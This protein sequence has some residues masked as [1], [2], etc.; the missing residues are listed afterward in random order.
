MV[1][2]EAA[3]PPFYIYSTGTMRRQSALLRNKRGHWEGKRSPAIICYLKDREFVVHR[4]NF[5]GQ[6]EIAG[7]DAEEMQLFVNCLTRRESPFKKFFANRKQIDIL[8]KDFYEHNNGEAIAIS[9]VLQQ[10]FCKF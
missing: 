10:K 4:N 5:P 7:L 6:D 9:Q 2:N 8:L 1:P 3:T